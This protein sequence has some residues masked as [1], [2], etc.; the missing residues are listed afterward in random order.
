M[1]VKALTNG[2]RADVR[3]S[4]DRNGIVY[5]DRYSPALLSSIVVILLLCVADAFLT[6]LL[7][8]HGAVELNPLMAY[9]LDISPRVF[10]A[11]K[12]T[13]TSLSVFILL[14]YSHVTLKNIGLHIRKIFS[15]I[16]TAMATV[17]AWEIFLVLRIVF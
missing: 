4:G 17:V 11:A 7:I 6:V 9:Y 2:S 14:I 13:L 15:V 1:V 16:I 8:G 3:R 12:Y 10:L 5:I